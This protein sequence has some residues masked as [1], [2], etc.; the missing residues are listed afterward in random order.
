[1]GA[2]HTAG[3]SPPDSPPAASAL[4]QHTFV[5]ARITCLPLHMEGG[6]SG[7][8]NPWLLFLRVP[9][10]AERQMDVVAAVAG[11]VQLQVE[12]QAM[13]RTWCPGPSPRVLAMLASALAAIFVG[14]AYYWIALAVDSSAGVGA[15]IEQTMFSVAPVVHLALVGYYCVATRRLSAH[16]SAGSC[17]ATA[18]TG[19]LALPLNAT[20]AHAGAFGVGAG[21]GVIAAFGCCVAYDILFRDAFEQACTSAGWQCGSNSDLATV[22]YHV[23]N[24][25]VAPL[26]LAVPLAGMVLVGCDLRALQQHAT[27][28]VRG[29]APIVDA[30]GLMRAR[31][32][33]LTVCKESLLVARASQLLLLFNCALVSVELILAG[34][35]A[36]D[37]AHSAQPLQRYDVAVLFTISATTLA[38]HAVAASLHLWAAAAFTRAGHR[39][40]AEAAACVAVPGADSDASL[41]PLA[42]RALLRASVPQYSFFG[43]PVTAAGAQTTAGVWLTL[44]SYSVQAYLNAR[45]PST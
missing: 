12:V 10:E 16:S 2:P 14:D 45:P 25:T 24:I 43:A 41:W 30:A 42:A 34:F 33:L 3:S 1:M 35:S 26:Q 27:V 44:V 11:N 36:T 40:S 20:L 37:A 32:T 19:V 4:H 23:S 28:S 22:Y 7:G 17:N 21:L 9:V 5:I 38:S 13:S 8:A 6:P 18:A 29:S 31:R 39:A 15:I